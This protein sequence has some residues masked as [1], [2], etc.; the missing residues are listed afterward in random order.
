VSKLTKKALEEARA[1]LQ[2]HAY[3]SLGGEYN[4]AP[5]DVAKM[6]A[7][8]RKK[9]RD[10][11]LEGVAN[12]CDELANFWDECGNLERARTYTAFAKSIRSGWSDTALKDQP[13]GEA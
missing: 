4:L 2:K 7:D 1:L 3:C 5:D 6:L 9:A 12:V 13:D 11:A 10:D 8:V